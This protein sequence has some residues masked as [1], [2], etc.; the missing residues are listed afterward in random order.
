MLL[1]IIKVTDNTENRPLCYRDSTDTTINSSGVFSSENTPAFCY[2]V[3]FIK[4][5]IKIPENN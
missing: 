2:A 5:R 1:A 4:P 3:K